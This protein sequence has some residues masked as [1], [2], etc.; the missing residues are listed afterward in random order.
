M[1]WFWPTRCGLAQSY[2]I[3][4]PQPGEEG[5]RHRRGR[6]VVL[7]GRRTVR[8]GHC[9]AIGADAPAADWV[10]VRSLLI[11]D[12][13]TDVSRLSVPVRACALLRLAITPGRREPLFALPKFGFQEPGLALANPQ[14]NPEEGCHCGPEKATTE[15]HGRSGAGQLAVLISSGGQRSGTARTGASLNQSLF[16][17]KPCHDLPTPVAMTNAANSRVTA[18]HG[19][20]QLGLAIWDAPAAGQRARGQPGHAAAERINAAQPP[21]CGSSP[22][23]RPPR[24]SR[25]EVP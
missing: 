5:I 14:G 21:R 18:L 9:A 10:A 19:A 8:L 22:S 17:R 24:L 23:A 4:L 2:L 6:G 16:R 20:A 12:E 3:P 15:A 1:S 13:Q 7:V 11:R 25:K